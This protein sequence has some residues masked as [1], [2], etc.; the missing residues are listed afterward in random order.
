M[1]NDSARQSG[2]RLRPAR[3]WNCDTGQTLNLDQMNMQEPVTTIRKGNTR[4]S[5]PLPA[6]NSAA[7]MALDS[8]RS[9]QTQPLCGI[10]SRYGHGQNFSP[11]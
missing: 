3:H 6:L 10:V 1:E 7:H 8:G 5:L 2:Q 11:A 9:D 4:R